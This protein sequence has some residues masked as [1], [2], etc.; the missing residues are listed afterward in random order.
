MA[1]QNLHLLQ[2]ENLKEIEDHMLTILQLAK[3]CHLSEQ[4]ILE[5]LTTIMEEHHNE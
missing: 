4:D 3:N 5:M 2:E 1:K